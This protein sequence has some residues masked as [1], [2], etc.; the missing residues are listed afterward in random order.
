MADTHLD[1]LDVKTSIKIDGSA[2]TDP[3]VISPGAVGTTE[4]AATG[5]TA[6][7][8]AAGA[9]TKAKALVFISTERTATGSEE[10][11]AHGLG[12]TPASVL[13]IPTDTSPATAGVFTVTEGTHTS[14][15][16]LVTVTS[17][18]KYKV[19]AWA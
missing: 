4:L 10:T 19:F 2:I 12:A 1:G 17:G 6:A 9:V 16:V 8:L 5:V 15:N 18:K 3:A 11:I 13:V 14:T 7:K